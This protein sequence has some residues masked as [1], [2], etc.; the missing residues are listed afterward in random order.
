MLHNPSNSSDTQFK[1]EV[2]KIST[3]DLIIENES[4]LLFY[5]DNLLKKKVQAIALDMEGDQ[6][7]LR[8]NYSISIFQ[9]F[10]GENKVIIDVLKI[11]NKPGLHQFLTCSDIVKVMFSCANDIFMTQ[12][13]LGCTIFPVRDIAVGQKLLGLPI[14]LSS[15][16][17]IDR[18]KK[19]AFQR[20]NWLRR[21]IR[22]ELLNY[23]INDVL[24]LF[25][26]E[27][28]I[29]TGLLDQSLYAR[30][31]EESSLL[32]K[33][34]FIINQFRLYKEKFPGYKRFKPDKKRL[35]ANVWVFRELLG[36]YYDLPVG[37]LLSKQSMVKVI[38]E[39]ENLLFSLE[40]ELN[41]N[42]KNGKKI[43][44]G[45]IEKYYKR[46]VEINSK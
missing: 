25:N 2:S 12:N 13:V 8:Y 36:K 32:S 10:D 14:N 40:S 15:Y 17:K 33:R 44:P 4:D 24:E 18:E 39:P 21:P 29:E 42:R 22:S 46:A 16:L 6:G 35:A 45:L 11:G 31:L 3:I 19:D 41:R 1:P 37:F 5:L 20:A 30:Y 43:E 7:L 26:I 38:K 34:N 9:C 28:E 23:A 27:K